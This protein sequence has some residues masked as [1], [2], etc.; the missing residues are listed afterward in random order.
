MK[1]IVLGLLTIT[2]LSLTAQVDFTMNAANKPSDSLLI[3]S[4][5]FSKLIVADKN[6]EFKSKL[7]V[8][9]GFYQL[10]LGEQVTN[11]YLK[12]GNDLKATLDYNNFDA[13]LVY[14]GKGA[15]ENNFIAKRLASQ[16]DKDYDAAMNAGDEAQLTAEINKIKEKTFSSI[17]KGLDENFT[18]LFK[19]ST[20]AELAGLEKY[21][22]QSFGLKK[23]NGTNSP[24]FNYENH[25]GGTTKLEDFKGKYVYIDVWATWCGPCR[26]EIPSLKK[27]EEAY[28][29]KNIEF[30]SI[31]IDQQKDHEKWKKFVTE[32]QLGGVQL[33][34]DKDWNSDFAKSYGITGIPRFILIGPDGKIVNADAPRPSSP[35]LTRLLDSV[36]K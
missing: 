10:K 12:N 5:T 32:K 9:D 29:G 16:N 17:P 20:E 28:H 11:L 19:K 36:V 7:D 3:R 35:E 4:R 24:S 25:K 22:K 31:S 33:M 27:T 8:T 30:V 14:T 26:A 2:S 34:A 21:I 13:S 15:K 1:K 18:N 23:L 6:G